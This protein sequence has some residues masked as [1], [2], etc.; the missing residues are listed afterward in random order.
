MAKSKDSAREDV[1]EITLEEGP[2]EGDVVSAL[3]SA[4]GSG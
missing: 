2:S 3:R 1:H 4:T